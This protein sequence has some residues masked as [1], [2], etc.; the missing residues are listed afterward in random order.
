MSM[1]GGKWSMDVLK[2][3]K[4]LFNVIK[5]QAASHPIVLFGQGLALIA[6]GEI[7]D[8]PL[9]SFGGWFMFALI[10]LYYAVAFWQMR[11]TRNAALKRLAEAPYDGQI[12]VPTLIRNIEG[13]GT[14]QVLVTIF[15]VI[16]TLVAFSLEYGIAVTAIASAFFALTVIVWLVTLKRLP[17]IES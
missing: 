2:L 7:M 12:V 10:P 17:S 11:S 14:I 5:G 3:A 8:A 9:I 16:L 6:L 4:A 1:T 15:A 13:I